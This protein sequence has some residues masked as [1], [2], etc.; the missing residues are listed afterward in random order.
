MDYINGMRSVL[1]WRALM[2]A[3]ALTV[4]FSA[5]AQKTGPSASV[6]QD[7]SLTWHGIT[8]YGVIDIGLQYQTHGAP[9]R[10]RKSVV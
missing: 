5:F 3:G 2:A 7:E 1:N 6:P 9:L 10:D 4:S 8:L